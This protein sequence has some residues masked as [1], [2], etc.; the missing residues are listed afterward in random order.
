MQFQNF[1]EIIA[2]SDLQEEKHP[3]ETSLTNQYILG[4]SVTGFLILYLSC[5]SRCATSWFVRTI[6]FCVFVEKLFAIYGSGH[7]MWCQRLI[8]SSCKIIDNELKASFNWRITQSQ[9][10]HLLSGH[11]HV[12]RMGTIEAISMHCALPY[13]C[14]STEPSL[15]ALN[16]CLANCIFQ[17]PSNAYCGNW[18]PCAKQVFFGLSQLKAQLA[19]WKIHQTWDSLWKIV[20]VSISIQ[21]CME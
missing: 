11:A 6:W 13:Q 8:H 18:T 9:W 19:T 2:G 20:W 15:Y 10:L 21:T 1:S 16:P 5:H 14:V 4:T 7:I 12:W 17:V 3:N